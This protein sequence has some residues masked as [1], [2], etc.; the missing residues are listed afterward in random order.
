MAEDDEGKS[1]GG[2]LAFWSTLPGVL[3]GIAALLTAIVGVAGLW[4]SLD[5]GSETA[6]TPDSN[7][8]ITS[9]TTTEKGDASGGDVL[10][11]GRL[12]MRDE[13]AANLRRKRVSV[14]D[15]EADLWL[16]GAGNPDFGI[17]YA[18]YGGLFSDASD[19]SDK[20][21]CVAAL[22]ARTR[23]RLRLSD[24]EKGSTFC[25]K[26]H[27]GGIAALR[28]VSPPVIGS[29]QLVFEYTLWA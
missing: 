5:N 28:I 4:R 1:R 6:Q 2:F 16:Q 7:V 8:A 3:T 24:L 17:L 12:T 19:A 13:D 25:L 11:A 18:P 22:N 15:P 14:G 21:A 23:D 29:P 9:A 26:T 27:E 10:A 20:Q